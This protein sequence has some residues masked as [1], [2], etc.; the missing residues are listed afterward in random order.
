[1]PDMTCNL[2]GGFKPTTKRF[3]DLEVPDFFP[4]PRWATFALIENEKFKG[5]IWDALVVTAP[6]PAS[7][8]KLGAQSQARTYI[9]EVT[10]RP[11]TISLAPTD[12]PITS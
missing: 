7:L 12:Q 8:R 2:N 6:C 9:R 3:A 11:D 4:T 10:A 1:M 5:D